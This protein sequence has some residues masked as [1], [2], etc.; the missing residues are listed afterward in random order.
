MIPAELA[1]A[2]STT[3]NNADLLVWACYLANGFEKWLDVEDL[4]LKAFQLAPARLSWR[5]KPEIPDYKK[6]SKALQELEDP[7]RSDHLGLLD[8]KGKYERKLSAAG[9]AWCKL[10]ESLLNSLYGGERPVPTAATQDASRL[11]R[12]VDNSQALAEFRAHGQIKSE[13]W[14]LADAL[15]CLQDSEPHV[16]RSRID[17]LESAAEAHGR[18]DLLEFVQSLRLILE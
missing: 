16:W 13:K 11:I 9:F 5:T 18:L 1:K 2:P 3:P 7:K 6:I 4:F 15:R 8:K 10:Y 14:V 17:Q 12:H